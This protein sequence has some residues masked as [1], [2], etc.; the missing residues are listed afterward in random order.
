MAFLNMWMPSFIWLPFAFAPVV[1]H[2]L[3]SVVSGCAGALRAPPSSSAGWVMRR[4]NFAGSRAGSRDHCDM[5]RPPTMVSK[6]SRIGLG[7][8]SSLSGFAKL[9]VP[10]TPIAHGNCAG[11]R[12]WGKV[13]DKVGTR[14]DRCRSP[15][16]GCCWSH[17]WDRC[18]VLQTSFPLRPQQG[19]CLE[20]DGT[21][22]VHFRYLS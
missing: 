12:P 18:G 15:Q 6:P 19:L 22:K 21:G 4:G 10:I 20:D 1:T 2:L 11:T 17:H 9:E 7:W 14:T 8:N 5:V 3:Q 16:Q 13:A